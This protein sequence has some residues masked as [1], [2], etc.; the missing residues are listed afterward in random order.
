M[1]RWILA[2]DREAHDKHSPS[3]CAK[4]SVEEL[5]V[6]LTLGDGG[7]IQSRE[8]HAD[9][10]ASASAPCTTTLSPSAA[11]TTE[12]DSARGGKT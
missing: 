4:C 10:A 8:R 6:W 7:S 5:N 12:Y 3:Q 11:G 2:R 9:V 1:N